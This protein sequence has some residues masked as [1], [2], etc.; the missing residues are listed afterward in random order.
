M[1]LDDKTELK[2]NIKWVVQLVAF[3]VALVYGYAKLDS[4]I[5]KLEHTLDRIEVEMLNKPQDVKQDTQIERLE[6]DVEKAKDNILKILSTHED[7]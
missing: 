1:K 4:R 5:A 3:I 7:C 6:R 2:L